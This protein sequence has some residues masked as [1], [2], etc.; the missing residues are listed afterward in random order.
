VLPPLKAADPQHPNRLDLAQWIVDPANPLTA[1]VTVNRIWMH[2]FGHGLVETDNDFGTQGAAPTHP[3]LLDWLATELVR[4]NWSQKA[5]HRLIVTSAAYRQT[6]DVRPDLANADPENKLLA[7]QSRVRLDA[8]IVRDVG[9]CASGLLADRIGGPS[10]FPPQPEGVMGLGQ[11]KR[12]WKTSTGPD[13]YRRGLYTFLWR[14]TPHPQLT[15]FDAPDATSTCTRRLRSNTPLQA[16]NLLNDAACVEFAQ[17]L[18]ARVLTDISGGDDARID[19][20]F[21]LCTGRRPAAGEREVLLRLLATQ[22]ASFKAD[23]QSARS[24]SGEKRPSDVE[25]DRFAAWVVVARAVLNLDETIT[26]E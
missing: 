19:H 7:R 12:E 4:Q 1:R 15:S 13:R 16:L 9:L 22:Q 18:A 3:E 2:Y 17:A 8:E 23:E 21:R 10:V 26:R 25:P 11:V 14:G 20:A 5:I 6:S 24:V